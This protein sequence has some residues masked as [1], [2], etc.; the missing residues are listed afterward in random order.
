MKRSGFGE[1]A[2][3]ANI[4]GPVRAIRSYIGAN[5]YKYTVATDIFYPNREDSKVELRGH[6]GLPGYGQA[7][8]FTTELTGLTYT[9]PSN[10]ALPID[11]STDA[12]T[13]IVATTGSSIPPSWQL[14][15][16][17]AGSLVT[18]RTLDTDITGLSESTVLTDNSTPTTSPCT[19]DGAYWGQ[20]GINITSPVNSVPATD[21]TLTADPRTF[22]TKRIRIF[23]GPTFDAA[24]GPGVNARATHPI[25][26]G[27]TG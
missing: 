20:N 10:T 24:D 19:G 9:D 11:G 26:A 13:P 15:Q 3:I 16:G 27:V 7:D 14:V 18:V 2:F 25:T 23:Q 5:S 6:S 8:D 12:F 1:G 17:A 4:S 21:P 22:V